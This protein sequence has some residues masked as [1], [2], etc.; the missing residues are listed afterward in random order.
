[1]ETKQ[2]ISHVL[3]ALGV[4]TQNIENHLTKS[5]SRI[6][7][8][9]EYHHQNDE[10]L[11]QWLKSVEEL[12]AFLLLVRHLPAT[13]YRDCLNQ[14][15]RQQYLL[16]AHEYVS[17]FT[18]TGFG[19]YFFAYSV[20][21]KNPIILKEELCTSK[22]WFFCELPAL[23]HYEKCKTKFEI[24]SAGSK[25]RFL[26]YCA[27]KPCFKCPNSVRIES[28]PRWFLCFFSTSRLHQ[29]A[30]KICGLVYFGAI[31]YTTFSKIS[32]C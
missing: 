27:A 23:C 9:S 28:K 8:K 15:K 30:R 24:K 21:T 22:N 13:E 14:T 10:H 1:M 26:S 2:K 20:N 11:D 3:K 17:K 7:R 6:K 19:S 32:A 25:A 12:D 16:R 5:I 18:W 29:Q 4:F 31:F